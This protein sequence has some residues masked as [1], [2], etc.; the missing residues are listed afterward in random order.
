VPTPLEKDKYFKTGLTHRVVLAVP[1]L[2]LVYWCGLLP[3]RAHFL[4]STTHEIAFK[5]N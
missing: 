1:L 4:Q 2:A 5:I 3:V